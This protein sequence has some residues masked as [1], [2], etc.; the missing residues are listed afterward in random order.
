MRRSL[1]FVVA[2][3]LAAAA[4]PLAGGGGPS[5]RDA[6]P[7]V[8]VNDPQ[9]TVAM[10]Q[11]LER[12]AGWLA[13]EECRRIFTD[14]TDQRGEPLA[15]RLASF[16]VDGAVFLRWIR[17]RDGSGTPQCPGPLAY[18]MPGGRVVFLC[19][20]QFAPFAFS[21]PDG[22]AAVVL[23]EALHSL[24]LGENPP[25]SHEITRRVRSRCAR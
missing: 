25:S 23:H 22:A 19:T 17:W 18:T 3:C 5:W 4:R 7:G 13:A 24:G 16:G 6:W 12:A 1:A 9:A 15:N 2:L 21:D 20:R 14:F 10:V 11:A 8:A